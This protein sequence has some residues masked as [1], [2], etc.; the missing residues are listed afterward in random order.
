MGVVYAR[1]LAT[2]AR[3]RSI[4]ARENSFCFVG[5]FVLDLC[6]DVYVNHLEDSKEDFVVCV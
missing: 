6:D 5:V 1:H 4:S 3:A 2:A